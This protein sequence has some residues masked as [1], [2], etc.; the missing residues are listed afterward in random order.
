MNKNHKNNL[1]LNGLK[2]CLGTFYDRKLLTL[3]Y[4]VLSHQSMPCIQNEPKKVRDN[5][6]KSLLKL[7]LC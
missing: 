2:V 6:K 5:G 1:F 3:Q 7:H 4:V